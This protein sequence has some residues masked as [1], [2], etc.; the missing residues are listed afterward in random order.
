MTTLPSTDRA[1][2]RCKAGKLG[3]FVAGSSGGVTDT[4]IIPAS[5]QKHVLTTGQELKQLISMHLKLDYRERITMLGK[6]WHPHSV[7]K[8]KGHNDQLLQLLADSWGI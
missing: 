2:P 7:V 5:Q 1:F 6:A 4:F 3:Q 8:L